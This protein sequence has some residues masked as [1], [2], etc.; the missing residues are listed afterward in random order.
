MSESIPFHEKRS[1]ALAEKED[2]WRLVVA[3]DGT[4]QVEHECSYTNPYR[5]G[6]S[7]AG[8]R[9]YAVEEFLYGDHDGTAKAKLTALLRERGEA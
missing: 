8:K 3:D 5:A 9:M 2:S 1:G 6:S 4:S 7:N